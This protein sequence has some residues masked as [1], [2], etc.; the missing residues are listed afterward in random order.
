MR[1]EK[2]E[3]ALGSRACSQLPSRQLQRASRLTGQVGNAELG[4]PGLILGNKRNPSVLCAASAHGQHTRT[5]WYARGKPTQGERGPVAGPS[6]RSARGRIICRGRPHAIRRPH[7]GSGPHVLG[8]GLGSRRDGGQPGQASQNRDQGGHVQKP[9]R[10]KQTAVR[11]TGQQLQTETLHSFNLPFLASA[12]HRRRVPTPS[13]NTQPG[14]CIPL[15]SCHPPTRTRQV[16]A[17]HRT[18]RRGAGAHRPMEP[19]ARMQA[20]RKCKPS[21]SHRRVY[22]SA[23][24]PSPR[25]RLRHA[26]FALLPAIR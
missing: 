3:L 6:D 20:V 26:C 21:P 25:P 2:S 1:V 7:K 4:V 12:W 8:A 13:I 24:P 9:S 23:T 18:T 15:T 14:S 5:S 22:P 17:S 11:A 19:G 16:S 10:M